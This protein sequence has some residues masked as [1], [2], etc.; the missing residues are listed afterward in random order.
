MFTLQYNLLTYRADL[1]VQLVGRQIGH[2][3]RHIYG[4][5]VGVAISK[6]TNCSER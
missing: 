1:S 5:R 6:L 4:M 2:C 3:E